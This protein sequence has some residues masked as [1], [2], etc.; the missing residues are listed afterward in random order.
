MKNRIL[1]HFKI[2]FPLAL[3]LAVTSQA[4]PW[5]LTYNEGLSL[6]KK[7][8]TKQQ[9]L[10]ARQTAVGIEENNNLLLM[11]LGDLTR[12]PAIKNLNIEESRKILNKKLDH[13]KDLQVNDAGLLDS[14]GITRISLKAPH[15][16]GA[17][18]SYR[19]YFRK[20]KTLK[21]STAVIGSIILKEADRRQEGIIIAIPVFS[22]DEEFAGIVFFT[23]AVN[24]LIRDFDP[25]NPTMGE[26]WVIDSNENILYNSS[27]L[28]DGAVRG[29]GR[30]NGAGGRIHPVG[31]GTF[32]LVFSGH[33]DII[34][35]TDL[36]DKILIH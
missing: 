25:L 26:S 13:I 17:N 3:L 8:F 14:K 15:F 30:A 4:I 31:H 22:G 5:Y 19:E 27:V 9:L 23:I 10:V 1:K 7:Q 33:A 11:E 34:V 16:E 21:K 6:I 29:V 36:A 35:G 28:G 24:E 20:A 12:E 2:I 18:F 32:C